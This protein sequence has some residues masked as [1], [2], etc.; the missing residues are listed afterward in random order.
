MS[1]LLLIL[2]SNKNIFKKQHLYSKRREKIKRERECPRVTRD[3]YSSK[4]FRVL[5]GNLQNKHTYTSRQNW[6]KEVFSSSFL[7]LLLSIPILVR[8]ILE[9][10]LYLLAHRDF[11][12]YLFVEVLL[13]FFL[14]V[15]LQNTKPINANSSSRSS[16]SRT[17]KQ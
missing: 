17:R 3:L 7:F 11:A 8:S 15:N 13:L 4:W 14:V 9:S 2:K 6:K 12:S 10:S 16:S 5:S 1:V